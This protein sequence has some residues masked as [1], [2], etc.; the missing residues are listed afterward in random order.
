VLTTGRISSEM[1]LK[2]A[3][4]GCPLAASLTGATSLAAEAAE[5]LGITLVTYVRGD[6]MDVCT[7]PERIEG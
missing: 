7:H 6:R 4:A 1:V 3:V 2:A 5:R